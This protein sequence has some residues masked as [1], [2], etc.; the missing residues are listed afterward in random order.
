MHHLQSVREEC[1]YHILSLRMTGENGTVGFMP[2][3]L[4][5]SST[6]ADL[7]RARMSRLG[8]DS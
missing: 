5:A 7:K 6:Y 3:S 8:Y 1:A 4:N 2:P